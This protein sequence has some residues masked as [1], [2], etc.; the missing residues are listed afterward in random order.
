MNNTLARIN[1]YVLSGIISALI[2]WSLGYFILD[3]MKLY[4]PQN[5]YFNLPPYSILLVIVTPSI[6][7]AMVVAEIFLSNPTHHKANWR[8][9][10]RAI[11]RPVITAGLIC[12]LVLSL[13]NWLLL[14]SNWY[15]L[16]VKMISWGLIGLF[17][18]LADSVSWSFYSIEGTGSKVKQRIA[19]SALLG[20]TTGLLSA[21][22]GEATHRA[23]G[24]YQ[25]PVGFLLLGACLGLA[26]SFTARPSYQ[27]ALRAGQGFEAV[28]P[29]KIVGS[30]VAQK[31][32]PRLQN[33]SLK[34]IPD[35][36]DFKHI[37]EGLSI[38]LPLKTPKPIIIGSS[39]DA[40][41]YIPHIPSKCASLQFKDGNLV[42]RA[43]ANEAVRVQQRQVPERKTIILRH[44]QILTLY[45]E[46]DTEKFYRFVFY[47]RFL[48]PQ[49]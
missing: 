41:I 27:V 10:S 2:S 29:K 40:D 1:F 37:E 32:R 7:T 15:G 17:V 5:L 38:Q 24:K 34:F 19:Q 43:L 13:L 23:L 48:D 21:L 11:L 8:I 36:D 47:N 30:R 20:V 31:L 35:D 46:D 22:F 42:L 28:K 14:E 3:L 25:E 45:H 18:G 44:N 33:E 4:L 12:G 26:L 16:I 9:L 6:A 39:Q 49:A